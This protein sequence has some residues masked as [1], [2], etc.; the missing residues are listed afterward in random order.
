[1]KFGVVIVTYNRL[2]LLKECV[3]ACLSQTYKFNSIIIVNNCSTD[4]TDE[5]LSN[6]NNN[7][8]HVI[9]CDTNLGGAGGFNK[10]IEYAIE[11]DDS[12][13]LLI[14]DD[15]AIIE[16]EYNRKIKRII[17][18]TTKMNEKIFAY[19]GTVVTDN[20]ILTFTRK[21]IV[22]YHFEKCDLNLYKGEFFDYNCSSFCG[23]YISMNIIKKIGPPKKEFFIWYDDTEYCMRFKKYTIIRNV[24]DAILDHKAPL[25]FANEI[26]WKNY[27]GIRNLLYIEKKYFPFF[28]CTKHVLK[29]IYKTIKSLLIY[30]FTRNKENKKLY[31]I[32]FWA[33]WDFIRNKYGFNDKFNHLTFK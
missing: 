27:Y 18:K 22:K 29:N 9:N 28:V 10:G 6:L 7:T 25:Q 1:M 5:Y 17:D 30:T 16:E 3:D 11:N 21:N 8:I 33:T 2:N 31:I 13:Y 20:Q 4:G 26:T 19:S 32:Y 14:I 24:N 12:D 15:D 23:L